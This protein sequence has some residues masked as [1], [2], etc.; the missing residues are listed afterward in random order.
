MSIDKLQQE[1]EQLQSI[2]AA[3]LTPEQLTQ[4][5]EKLSKMMDE[6]ESSLAEIKLQLEQIKIETN[7]TDSE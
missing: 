7:D 1:A 6:S 4:L 5:V 2:D 3:N